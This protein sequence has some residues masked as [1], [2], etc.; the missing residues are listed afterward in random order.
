MVAKDNYFT[1]GISGTGCD[2]L[3]VPYLRRFKLFATIYKKNISSSV[4]HM[5][6]CYSTDA[7]ANEY[8]CWTLCASGD[9]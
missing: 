5:F 4:V 8:L 3:G 2:V 1:N 6:C 7:G 9:P